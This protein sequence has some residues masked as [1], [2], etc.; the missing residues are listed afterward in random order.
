MFSQRPLGATLFIAFVLL[1]S[2]VIALGQEGSIFEL[3]LKPYGSFE[4]GDIDTVDVMNFAVHVNIPLFSYRQRGGILQMPIA[5]TAVSQI[6]ARVN[7]G[8]T[9]CLQGCYDFEP[10]PPPWGNIPPYALTHIDTRVQQDTTYPYTL[11]VISPDGGSHKIGSWNATLDGSA[12]RV[13]AGVPTT[14]P[15]SRWITDRTGVTHTTGC[16][17]SGTSA[18]PFSYY[19]D[20]N[21]NRITESLDP[22]TGSRLGYTDTMNRFLTAVSKKTTDFSGCTGALPTASASLWSIPAF[23]G[24]TQTYKFCNAV[25]IINIPCSGKCLTYHSGVQML[26]AI[27]Q[28]NGTSWVFQYDSA[29]PNNSLSVGYGDL[30]KITFPTAGSLS[31]TYQGIS[32]FGCSG[33]G[34]YLRGIATR[35]LDAQD[36]QGPHTWT[37]SRTYTV[38]TGLGSVVQDPLGNQTVHTFTDLANTGFVN[39]AT[40]SVYETTTQQYQGTSSSGVLLRT[41]STDYTTAEVLKPNNGEEYPAALPIRVTTTL[42]NGNQTKV[43][44]DYNYPLYGNYADALSDGNITAKREYDYGSGA[45]G[46]LL[47]TTSKTYMDSVNSAYLNANLVTPLSSVAV[48]NNIGTRASYSTFNYDEFGLISSGVTVQHDINPPDGVTR[49][50]L[51]STHRWLSNGS[52]VSQTPCNVSVP[53]G[54]YVVSSQ[55]YFDTGLIQKST[56]PCLYSSSYLYSPTYFGAYPT[57]VTNS[58]NQNASSAY[59]FNTGQVTSSQDANSQSTGK[60]YDIMGRLTHVSYPD[61]GQTTY[62]YTDLGGSTCTQATSPPYN[63]ITTKAISSALNETSTA[64]FDGI[65]RVSQT[66]L[67]SDPDGTTYTATTYDGNGRISTQSNPY[68]FIA[69]TTY[70]ITTYTYDPLGRLTQKSEPDSSVVKTSYTGNQ[71]TVTDETGNQRKSQ[72]DGLG[73][74]T[75]AWEAPNNTSYNYQTTYA[76]DALDN[77]LSVIQNGSRAR[78]FT[79]DSLSRLVCAANPEVQIVTCPATGTA[80]F[81]AT[82]YAYDADS[83]LA[84]KVATR[85]D[86]TGTSTDTTNYF[87]D[88][89]NRLIEKAYIGLATPTVQ[90]GFD[91]TTLTGCGQAPPTIS[92]PTNLIGRRSS[93][94]DGISGSSWSFDA[95]GRPVTEART[96]QGTVASQHNIGY[97]YNLDGSINTL[98][99]PSGDVVTY[100]QGGAGR[101]L[102]VSDS[103]NTYVAN[104]TQSVANPTHYTA[105]GALTSV[106]NGYT[107]SF[108]GIRSANN[109]GNRL[110]PVFVSANLPANSVA[111]ST[112]TITSCNVMS[113]IATVNV[114]SSAGIHVGD[115]VLVNG[116][117]PPHVL[118]GGVVVSVGAGQ[119][120]VSTNPA[121]KQVGETA[122][123][124]SLSD[125]SN[126][127]VYSLCYDFHMGVNINAGAGCSLG[128]STSGDNGNVF[129]ILNFPDTTRSAMFAYDPLN[130]LAQANTINTTSANCWSEVYTIDAWGNLTNR[131]GLSSMPTCMTEPLN[132]A[133]ATAQNHLPGLLYDTAGNV[134]NDG[135]GNTPTHDA[136]N[137]IATDAG[138]TYSYDA[139]GTRIEKSSG[140]MYW[141]G[142]GGE[143]LAESDLSGTVNEEYIYFNGARIARV[144]RPSGTVHYYFADPLGSASVITDANGNIEEQYYYYPYGGLVSSVGGDPN[145]YKFTGKE[146]DSESGL[147]NFGARYDSSSMGRFMTPDPLLN[148]GRPNNPQTWNRYAYALNNPLNVVDPTGLYDLVNNC[149]SDDTTCN[150][151][152]NQ[153]AKD[154]KNGL[155]DLQKK[156][157]KMKDGP[158]KTRLEGALKAIGTEGDQNGVTAGFGAVSNAAA[159]TTFGYNEQT[160]QVT[161]NVTFDPSKISGSNDYAIDAAHEGT[162]IADTEDPRYNNQSTTLSPFAGEYR[163]Y[164]TSAWAASALGFSS[165]G[166]GGRYPIWNSSWGAVDDKVLTRFITD[167]YKYRNGQHYEETKPHNPWDN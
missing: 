74:L 39:G 102:G 5:Y 24:G 45:P 100:T 118:S 97:A 144:D 123:G 133:P 146:R 17:G 12:Y 4:G 57:T 151:R 122:S 138:V 6:I 139:D 120:A 113:C 53:N 112:I 30:L 18:Q 36:G 106:T 154:L 116:D 31:Y 94:C 15:Y 3:G 91:G 62:C 63:L 150:K 28:P 85:P 93:M 95:M 27:V 130:R 159:E 38:P 71:T 44:M 7:F 81:G 72:V 161:A 148:S 34:Q 156:V 61:G 8:G 20:P 26:Q 84:T 127:Y 48:T 16:T 11:R 70:G 83:N 129:Q 59:D 125:E 92:F 101:L 121:G 40:C 132:A 58:L 134:I 87:Y 21:G 109:Y 68:R 79:Y 160:K 158:E 149:A 56:D 55:V 163:A 67:N 1:S 52:A 2:P 111:I 35:T 142:A 115:T 19:E 65:G 131:A 157:D 152:F 78:T 10:Q 43:E 114:A 46:P 104:H 42:A 50:N 117:M 22:L 137:R 64:V 41:T 32:P 49:G 153:R 147:D 136:E 128:S 29:D 126:T 135:I 89:L 9:G 13:S 162:H 54:G 90:Y 167:T 155:S 105:H 143:Y 108:D 37:Y 33:T 166:Y 119:V 107:S 69:E 73:R 165:L 96:T 145:H 86:Q 47:R 76:Y 75:S 140:R 99:Y 51:T 14:C 103:S 98:T 88:T 60:Q 80:P 110:Q 66:Q 25:V 164:Q 124:G 77:L 141:T 82:T 23:G